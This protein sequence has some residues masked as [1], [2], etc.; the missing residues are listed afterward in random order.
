MSYTFLENGSEIDIVADCSQAGMSYT[1]RF[2]SDGGSGVADCSQAGMS[3]TS[4]R[5]LVAEGMVADCSQAGMSYTHTSRT[6]L[7]I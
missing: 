5:W 2:T 1:P 7:A 4:R 6:T 3:Y